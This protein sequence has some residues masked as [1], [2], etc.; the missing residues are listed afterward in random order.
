MVSDAAFWDVG[1]TQDY[2]RTSRAFAGREAMA[3]L[4]TGRRVHVDPSARLTRSIVWDD[5]QVGAAAV[6]EDCILTDGVRIAAG[7][8]RRGEI[9]IA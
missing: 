3:D 9:V 6:I 7:E 8:T 4:G 1:T 2:W 5:V